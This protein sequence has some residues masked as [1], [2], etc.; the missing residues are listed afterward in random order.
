[1]GTESIRKPDIARARQLVRESGYDGKPLVVIHVTDRPQMNAAAIVTRTRLESIGFNAILKPMD[2][3]TSLTVRTRKEQPDRGGWNLLHTWWM[4]ADVINPAV[5]FGVGG[6]GQAAWFGWP[7]IPELDK[8][9]TEWVRATDP[10]RRKQLAEAI[11]KVALREVPYVPW[12][13]WVQ[14]TAFRKN[15]QGVVR[16]AAPVFWNVRVA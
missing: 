16:F 10:T 4:A 6:A 11:Q 12:G 13:E 9:T 15:V 14:P 1:V 2:W 3:S 8:L 7:D 5:H